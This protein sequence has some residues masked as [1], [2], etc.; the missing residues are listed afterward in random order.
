MD[1]LLHLL[2]IQNSKQDEAINKL[3]S[4]QETSLDQTKKLSE[5]INVIKEQ[6]AFFQESNSPDVTLTNIDFVSSNL[7]R[8]ENLLT[9]SFFN[10]G[11]R[12]LKSLNSEVLVFLPV[13]DSIYYLITLKPTIS[14][15]NTT[16]LRPKSSNTHFLNIPKNE[17]LDS[18]FQNACITVVANYI[19]PLTKKKSSR[20]FF[21]RTLKGVD[22]KFVGIYASPSEYRIMSRFMDTSKIFKRFGN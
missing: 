5:Q 22:G 3:T 16:D 6:T 11:G 4:I 21:F 7:N 9:Y 19:D 10:N 1:S 17:I 15:N 8:N 20:P 12:A 14:P 2:T 13:K 18:I